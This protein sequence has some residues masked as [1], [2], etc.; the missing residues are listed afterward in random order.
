MSAVRILHCADIHIGAA[1]T[2]IGEK[3]QSRRLEALLTFEKII[4]L[5]KENRVD[6]ILIAGDLFCSNTVPAQMAARVFECI[7]S[8]PEIKVVFAAGNHDPLNAESPFKKQSL[9]KNLYV[10]PENDSFFYFE[11]LNAKVC[12]RSFSEVYLKGER[13]F[14]AD[15]SDDTVNVMCQHGEVTSDAGSDYNA[16]TGEF[17]DNSGMDYIALGHIHKRSKIQRRGST[18]FA[19]CGCPE[20][21]GFDELG[22]KGVYIGEVDKGSADMRFYKTS[23]RNHENVSVDVSDCSDNPAAAQKI[24]AFLSEKYGAG[25]EDNLYKIVLTGSVADG[26]WFDPAEIAGRLMQT[27]YFAKVKDE[28]GV[29]EDLDTLK[30][31]NSLKGIFVQ[32]MLALIAEKPEEADKIRAALNIGLKAFSSEVGYNE[33]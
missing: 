16:I 23:I 26:C 29:F 19:Y 7:G 12:G 24:T 28:T 31:E 25:F 3:S 2:G 27:V 1:E 10:L 13:R 32:K 9:P 17:I 6:I 11:D 22:D 14:A 33:D 18:S 21:L 20:G 8:V 4:G 30:G 5:A 15:V